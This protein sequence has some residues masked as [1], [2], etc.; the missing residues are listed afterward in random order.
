MREAGARVRTNVFLRDLNIVGIRPS[1]G[2]RIEIVAD[3][4]PLYHGAQLVIDT[5]LVCALRGDSIPHPK[6]ATEDGVSL[7]RAEKKKRDTYPE[8]GERGSRAK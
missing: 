1:D 6:C 3:G 2:R 7:L 8:L 5:T 4:L